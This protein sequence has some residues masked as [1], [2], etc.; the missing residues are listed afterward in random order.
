[1][2]AME[3]DELVRSAPWV[4]SAAEHT[5]HERIL[6]TATTRLVRWN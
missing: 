2:K 3:I 5:A 4:L 6:M 1:M